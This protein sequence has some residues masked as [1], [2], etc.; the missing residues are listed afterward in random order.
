[1]LISSQTKFI[2]LNPGNKMCYVG[3]INYNYKIIK[4]FLLSK[5]NY[6]KKLN[7]LHHNFKKSLTFL[8]LLN[9]T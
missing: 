3:Y 4:T 2:F 8:M 6:L 5:K 1:M 9:T 7:N